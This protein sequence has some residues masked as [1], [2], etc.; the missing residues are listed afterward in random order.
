MNPGRWS[1]QFPRAELRE[2]AGLA[3]TLSHATTVQVLRAGRPGRGRRP[4][5]LRYPVYCRGPDATGRP[6][7]YLIPEKED[8][9]TGEGPRG[10]PSDPGPAAE[11]RARSARLLRLRPRHPRAAAQRAWPSPPLLASPSGTPEVQRAGASSACSAT[12]ASTSTPRATSEWSARCGPACA[13]R[14]P[15]TRSCRLAG[16]ATTSSGVLF[17]L[18]RAPARGF[19]P[20]GGRTGLAVT[21]NRAWHGSP[22][23]TT[24]A[25][26]SFGICQSISARPRP[27][28]PYGS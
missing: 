22:S 6:F 4:P 3:G 27:P 7:R 1:R 13:R 11:V 10:H 5:R 16:C 9:W 26:R 23:G 21:Q 17:T 19:R 25:R 2:I 28:P 8:P 24:G 18:A 14:G 12:L 15:L 20:A